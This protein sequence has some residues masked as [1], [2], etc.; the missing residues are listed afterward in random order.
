MLLRTTDW[1]CIPTLERGNEWKKIP[2]WQVL[3]AI[4]GCDLPV[5]SIVSEKP[6]CLQWRMVSV[7]TSL[8]NFRKGKRRLLLQFK[9]LCRL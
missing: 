2:F 3:H 7:H 8:D 1:V 6:G 9:I 4:G 5:F